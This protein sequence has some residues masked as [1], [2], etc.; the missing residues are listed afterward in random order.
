[1][2][3]RGR[4][5][6]ILKQV[7]HA[8]EQLPMFQGFVSQ[9]VLELTLQ[10]SSPLFYKATYFWV[11]DYMTDP[12]RF[13]GTNPSPFFFHSKVSSLEELSCVG[14]HDVQ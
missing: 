3:F 1:M 5:S 14:R 8:T 10:H 2:Y 9:E 12:M 13:M 4:N 11:M 6:H 7:L